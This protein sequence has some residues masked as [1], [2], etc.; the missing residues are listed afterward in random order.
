MPPSI[1]SS[2]SAK[3]T[4]LEAV[5][6]A[7]KA[8]MRLLNMGIPKEDA[9]FVMPNATQTEI[10]LS[11]NMRELRH[12]IELRGARD[13]Q[14]EIRQVAIELLK[15]LKQHAPDVFFDLEVDE[16]NQVV[17]KISEPAGEG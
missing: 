5:E 12:I 17:V 8:Y 3:A 2:C 6:T 14:W 7:K 1:A 10:V 15:I 9:R 16:E 13:A 11:A 4:F